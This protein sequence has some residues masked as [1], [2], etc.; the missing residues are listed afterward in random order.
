DLPFLHPHAQCFE[1]PLQPARSN[2]VRQSPRR[3]M[4]KVQSDR[5]GTW[6]LLQQFPKVMKSGNV[7]VRDVEN[8]LSK[9]H[10]D[11]QRLP[12]P[13]SPLW[14]V[15]WPVRHP[16]NWRCQPSLPLLPRLSVQKG[17]L[18]EP[19]KD[20]HVPLTARAQ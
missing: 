12:L 3:T 5:T 14:K 10:L 11:A 20:L 6:P 19:L 18:G 2:P 1:S 7:E 13:P 17:L 16:K 9:T 15:N 4:P 8:H